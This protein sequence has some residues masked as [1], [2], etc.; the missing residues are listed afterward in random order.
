MSI[1]FDPIKIGNMTIKNRFVRSATFEGFGTFDGKPSKA[2]HDLY[3]KYAEGEIG[4]IVSTSLVEHYKNLP[5]MAGL[6]YPLGFDEDR[7]VDAWRPLIDD[8]HRRGAKIAMQLMHPGRQE[9]PE[10]RGS[11]PIGPS[12]IPKEEGAVVPVALTTEEVAQYIERFAQAGRRVREAGF[13]AVQLHGAH[14]YLISNFLSPHANQRTDDYGGSLENRARFVTAILK[15]MR[16]LVGDDFPVM[17]KM[18]GRDFLDGGLEPGEAVQLAKIF[19]LT[20]IDGIEVSGGTGAERWRR[21]VTKNIKTEADEAYFRTFAAL[22]KQHLN[23][24]VIMVGGNRTLRLME[25]LVT[26]NTCDLISMSR[27]FIK[28]PDLI[29]KFKRG[30]Q[31][32][33]ACISCNKCFKNIFSSPVK[34]YVE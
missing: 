10:L 31:T 26:N 27:T 9:M 4:L 1:L 33:A 15:R 17:I 18:N 14:G 2:L 20:G 29:E 21:V 32:K 3:V 6:S 22:F 24:P 34:C 5:D 12:A 11:A 30:E 23:I 16:A 13:D 8:L 25:D 19:E 7:Y 28:E